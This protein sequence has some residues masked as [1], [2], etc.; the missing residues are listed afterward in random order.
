VVT[1]DNKKKSGR[2][3]QPDADSNGRWRT[4][5]NLKR[6]SHY[7]PHPTQQVQIFLKSAPNGHYYLQRAVKTDWMG[8]TAL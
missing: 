7:I 8:S 6:D 4:F 5:F 3:W 2:V 1:L